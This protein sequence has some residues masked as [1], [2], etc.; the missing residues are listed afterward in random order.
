MVGYGMIWHGAVVSTVAI[1]M[2]GM[3]L[4]SRRHSP[5]VSPSQHPHSPTVSPLYEV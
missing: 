1:V 5:T 4:C 3:A 2:V